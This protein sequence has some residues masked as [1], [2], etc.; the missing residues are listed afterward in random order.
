M[1]HSVRPSDL[2]DLYNFTALELPTFRLP[3][4]SLLLLPPVVSVSICDDIFRLHCLASP[5]VLKLFWYTGGPLFRSLPSLSPSTVGCFV[6]SVP[7][8]LLECCLGHP[9]G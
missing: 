7:L 2:F 8:V 5:Y 3:K 4:R 6:P 9:V 1:P